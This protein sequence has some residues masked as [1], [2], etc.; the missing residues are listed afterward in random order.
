MRATLRLGIIAK[1]K[2]SS[3]A[4]VVI[5]P[6]GKSMYPP[7]PWHAEFACAAGRKA[8][9]NVLTW[10]VRRVRSPTMHLVSTARQTQSFALLMLCTDR[11][12]DGGIAAA[13]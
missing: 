10:Q 13:E 1:Q 5:G 3:L 12:K 2:R 9:D 7:G 11:E 4:E 6:V 8:M